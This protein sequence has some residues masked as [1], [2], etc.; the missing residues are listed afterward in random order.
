[1]VSR[2]LAGSLITDPDRVAERAIGLAQGRVV[3]I[4][5]KEI[6]FQADTICL[7][8]DTPGAA[9]IAKAVRQALDK[10]GVQVRPLGEFLG[11]G[12]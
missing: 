3:A 10:A 4:T 9:T 2:K 12:L 11:R 7:H 1:L 5:G 8:G 6:R